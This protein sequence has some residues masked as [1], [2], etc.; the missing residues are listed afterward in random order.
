MLLGIVALRTGQGQRIDYD[1]EAMRITNFP[2]AN[3]YLTRP[4]RSGWAI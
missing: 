3:E 2:Q 4:Y 1:G